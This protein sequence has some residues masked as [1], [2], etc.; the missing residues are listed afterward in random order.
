MADIIQAQ[1]IDEEIVTPSADPVAHNMPG[2]GAVESVNGKTGAVVL[3]ADDVGAVAAETFNTA[4]QGKQD[5]LTAG[6]GAEIKDGVL[7]ATTL[8]ITGAAVGQIARITAVDSDGKPTA[9]EPV[10]MASGGAS[11]EMEIITDIILEKDVSTAEFS[12]DLNGNPFLL[13]KVIVEITLTK[14][15]KEF[16]PA[17]GNT[18]MFNDYNKSSFSLNNNAYTT[19]NYLYCFPAKPNEITTET[20]I[21]H[22]FARW[23]LE[24]NE[25]GVMLGKGRTGV[26]WEDADGNFYLP[27]GNI[28]GWNANTENYFTGR[29]LEKNGISKVSIKFHYDSLRAGAHIVIKGIRM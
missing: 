21:G 10:D 26:M 29:V 25:L 12:K 18:I 11:D 20:Y 22:L 24:I 9:W 7:S 19:D 5:K 27:N 28:G 17:A 8:G 13:K 1:I 15:N 14:E 23:E 4:M 16:S 6:A 2:G 3:T